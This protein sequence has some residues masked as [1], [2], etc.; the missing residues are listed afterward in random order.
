M[1]EGDAEMHQFLIDGEREDGMNATSKGR[2]QSDRRF[3]ITG[4]AR[5]N[6]KSA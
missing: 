3:D 4:L 6:K 1:S 5:S 2:Q